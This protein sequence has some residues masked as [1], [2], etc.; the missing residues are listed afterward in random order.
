[1]KKLLI[2]ICFLATIAGMHAQS[3]EHFSYQ[4]IVRN[5]SD[6]LV[7]NTPVSL[8][9]SILQGSSTG[10]T[11]YSETHETTTN[12]AGLL[13][14]LVGEGDVV[15]GSLA[16]INWGNDVH[17]IKTETD[18]T[19]GT[20]YD[21]VGTAVLHS[22]PYAMGSSTTSKALSAEYT[23]LSNRPITITT[24]Q[25]DKLDLL[26]ITAATNLDQMASDVALNSTKV[27][28]P[29]FGTTTGT[30]FDIVWS[31]ISDDVYYKTGKVGIGF[32][33]ASTFGSAVL[34]V[35]NGMVLSSGNI[36]GTSTK[37]PGTLFYEQNAKGFLFYYDNT[38]TLKSLGTDNITF[39]TRNHLFFQDALV[40]N[41][42]GIGEDATPGMDFGTNHMVLRDNTMN[43]FF[44]DTSVSASFPRNDWVIKINE[45][46]ASGQSYFAVKDSTSNRTPF[47]IR[48]GATDNSIGVAPNGKVN[49]GNGTTTETLEVDGSVKATA[50]IG[51]PNNLT[52]LVGMGTANTSNTGST[53]I[54]A[55][56]DD[57]DNGGIFL[58]TAHSTR[59][60]IKSDGTINDGVADP[61]KLLSL[62]GDAKFNALTAKALSVGKSIRKPIFTETSAVNFSTYDL[63]DRS[64]VLFNNAT[65]VLFAGF[66]AGK[67]GQKVHLINIHPTTTITV[68][69]GQV[70]SPATSNTVLNQ[71]DSMTLVYHNEGWVMT[72]YVS[73]P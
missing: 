13:T 11:V 51:S 34:G 20:E 57:N 68:F 3:P 33:D 37:T 47:T 17:Y 72:D 29:G 59:L 73:G 55:D 32:T 46:L 8:R 40:K 9:I 42:L 4:A 16:D 28:F 21:I 24:E 66:I 41:R 63:T 71:N 26:N 48:A 54:G 58:E 38:G 10:T 35:K 18:P 43:I 44:D 45:G 67:I 12:F 64:I 65:N 31:K 49:I 36:N 52:N 53:T 62:N 19:G 61:T 15:S 70:I 7:I 6:V 27:S 60:E 22:M 23:T 56:T 14:V 25:S 39:N 1:M 30:A 69:F 5:A 50:F 2:V